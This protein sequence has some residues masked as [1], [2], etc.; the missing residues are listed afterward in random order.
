MN[1]LDKL[2]DLFAPASKDHYEGSAGKLHHFYLNGEVKSPENYVSWMQIIRTAN[3]GDQIH[4]HINSYGGDIFTAIQLMRVIGESAA[5]VCC[6]VEGMCMSAA[7]LIFLSADQFQLSEHSMFMFHNYSSGAYGKGGEL[8]D[9]VV[10]HK[11]WS[12]ILLKDVYKNF[13]TEAE[14]RTILDN[15]DIWMNAQDV[16]GR[17]KKKYQIIN[18]DKKKTAGTKKVKDDTTITEGFSE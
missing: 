16:S 14:I 8:Y 11:K 17:L 10:H 6:S 2:E 7:T 4:I 3:Q 12:E 15:K 13:L 18:K 5:S 9:N 1:E